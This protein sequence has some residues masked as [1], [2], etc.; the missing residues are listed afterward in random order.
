MLLFSMPPSPRFLIV[1]SAIEQESNGIEEREKLCYML[2]FLSNF[3]IAVVGKALINT[4]LIL[5]L[6]FY[7]SI[8][9][10][11][12]KWQGDYIKMSP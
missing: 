4:R 7:F 1:I 8:L 12:K 10:K 3:G 5:V 11:K 6:I 2:N 9:R